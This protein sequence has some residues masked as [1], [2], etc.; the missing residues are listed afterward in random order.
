MVVE[1]HKDGAWHLHGLL[2][3]LP[4]QSVVPFQLGIHP[5][6]LVKGGFLNWTDYGEKFGFCSLGKI[7]DPI[8]VAF[9]IAKY[10]TKELGDNIRGR[11]S[12]MYFVSRGLKKAEHYGD[13]YYHSQQ[14]DNFLSYDYD[15]CRVGYGNL[16]WEFAC[17]HFD[18]VEYEEESNASREVAVAVPL[19]VPDRCDD[20][21]EMQVT[22][23]GWCK[24]N[25]SVSWSDASGSSPDP[26]SRKGRGAR[27][28]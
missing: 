23:A 25:M 7:R 15:F 11:G 24:G 14:L 28:S 22:M 8:K 2:R 21:E 3:G 27:N 12:H 20:W 13:C 18:G 17:E 16:P 19:S 10:I 9:Y 26:A 1:R 5:E 4:D 6:K